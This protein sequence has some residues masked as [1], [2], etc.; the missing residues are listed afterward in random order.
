MGRFKVDDYLLSRGESGEDKKETRVKRCVSLR[1]LTR[2][3]GRMSATSQAV[4]P[5]PLCYRQLQML[6]N[7]VWSQTASFEPEVA[8]TD[9]AIQ[10]LHWW[11]QHL[12]KWNG[13][14]V[15]PSKPDLVL[16][17]DASLLGWGARC[18][19]IPTGG[20]WSLEERNQ[21]HINC[22]E[23]L[24]GALAVKTFA[25]NLTGVHIHLKM[26]NTTAISYIN[27]MGG[28]RSYTLSEMACNFWSWCLERG[29]YLS[30]EHLLGIYNVTADVESRTLR[31]SLE[32]ELNMNVLALIFSQLGRCEVDLFATRLNHKLLQ[33]VSWRPDPFAIYIATNA[34]QVSWTN[35]KGYAFPTFAMIWKCLQ[36]VIQDK[37]HIILIAPV[38]S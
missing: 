32:W 22:L 6:K 9:G 1:E 34:F 13:K 38:Y 10:E 8:L 23:L 11:M 33:Y 37:G 12:E 4:L 28:T 16:E 26:D 3:L 19:E 36:K 17:T 18:E 21:L 30:A 7:H 14:P 24:W 35:I 2:L 27:R 5:A 15:L 31:S 20:L 25:K 29:I